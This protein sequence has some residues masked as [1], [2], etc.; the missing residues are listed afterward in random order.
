MDASG[1]TLVI[2][3]S[4]INPPMNATIIRNVI[5]IGFRLK[6]NDDWQYSEIL[7]SENNRW[8]SAT[9]DFPEGILSQFRIEGVA[10]S[11]SVLAIDNVIIEQELFNSDTEINPL[12]VD[13]KSEREYV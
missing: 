8:R 13:G 10:C 4:K 6:G 12:Y 1:G 7:S 9:I 2:R 11:G 5:R 3:P